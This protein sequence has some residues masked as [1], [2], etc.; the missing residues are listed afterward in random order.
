Y[1]AGRAATTGRTGAV[2]N[3]Q[4]PGCRGS[5]AYDV[6]GC[7]SLII[8]NDNGIIVKS[9]SPEE[10]ADKLA[11]L[12]SNPKARVEMGIKGRKRIQDKFSSV[13]IIDKTLQIYHDVVR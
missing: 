13:M 6:G 4:P 1:S 8:D 12:L 2:F 10:L 3:L 9:N 7:D 11:F 5:I